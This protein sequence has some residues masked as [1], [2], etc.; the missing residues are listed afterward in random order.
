MSALCVRSRQK[1]SGRTLGFH[2]SLQPPP[3]R[4][5]SQ[6]QSQSVGFLCFF[7]RSSQRWVVGPPSLSPVCFA[8]TSSPPWGRVRRRRFFCL[9]LLVVFT[10]PLGFLSFAGQ[11]YQSQTRDLASRRLLR[12]TKCQRGRKFI[13]PR[14]GGLVRGFA[15]PVEILCY[16]SPLGREKLDFSQCPNRKDFP[17]PRPRQAGEGRGGGGNEKT[18]KNK[19]KE[20]IQRWWCCVLFQQTNNLLHFHNKAPL[21]RPRPC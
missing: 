12:E 18:K 14:L 20:S 2:P 5:Q 8:F 3:P 6:S 11:V 10:G 7:R 21:P 16:G 17:R 4:S 1:R 19:K 15:N 13:L 9:L